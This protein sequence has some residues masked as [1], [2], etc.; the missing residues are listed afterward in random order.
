MNLTVREGLYSRTHR[1]GEP[2]LPDPLG[3][4]ATPPPRQPPSSIVL[5]LSGPVPHQDV[6]T[7]CDRVGH[8]LHQT[9]ADL[10]IC[11]VGALDDPDAATLDLVARLQLTARRLGRRVRLLDACGEL[12]DLI[13]LTGLSEFVPFSGE[14][15]LEA[16][17]K[18][19]QREPPSGVE[20]EADPRDPIT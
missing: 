14:L 7:L 16:R 5:V 10:M 17:G 2:S 11:D 18:A 19:E 13:E 3:P 15:P 4:A 8:L 6:L 1:K 12:Q 9:E 20:E